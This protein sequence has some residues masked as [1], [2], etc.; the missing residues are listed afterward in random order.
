MIRWLVCS[1]Y[2][3][4]ISWILPGIH[5]KSLWVAML[6][7]LMIGLFNIV[8]KP[9]LIILTI[10][11]TIVTLGVFLLIINALIIYWTSHIINGF[12]VLGFWSAFW[13][14][15]IYSCLKLLTFK[16]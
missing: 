11:V 3:M 16:N 13:F 4:L 10:P 9:I 14:G 6:V 1:L 5:I 15:L 8:V 2:V 7:S 12:E